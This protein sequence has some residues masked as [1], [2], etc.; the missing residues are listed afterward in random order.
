MC[1]HSDKRGLSICEVMCILLLFTFSWN[2][3]KVLCFKKIQ[4]G[5]VIIRWQFC[6]IHNINSHN[7]V[8]KARTRIST[9]SSKSDLCCTCVHV[10]LYAISY[11]IKRR[12]N[13]TH[14]YGADSRF[15]P[16]QWE[17]AL[18]CNDVSH[19]L[20]ASRVKP[21][22]IYIPASTDVVWRHVTTS[23]GSWC[24][25][26]KGEMSG[27]VCVTFTCDMYIYMSCL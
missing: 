21:V 6:Q 2:S 13:E 27:T 18:L 22:C 23:N 7:W 3:H 14:F 20:G 5:H 10:L 11:F 24:I 26:I 8:P 25:G 15:T 12:H 19:W 1:C 17:R 9:V 16:S 4:G